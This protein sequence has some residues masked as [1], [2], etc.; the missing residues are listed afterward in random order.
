MPEGRGCWGAPFSQRGALGSFPPV[1]YTPLTDLGL[2]RKAMMIK[3]TTRRTSGVVGDGTTCI[4]EAVL[5][6]PRILLPSLSVLLRNGI[7]GSSQSTK[8]LESFLF[9]EAAPAFPSSALLSARASAGSRSQCRR[10]RARWCVAVGGV[11]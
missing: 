10:L 6:H 3:L 2:I 1:S 11:W 9:W 5:A 8:T 7:V 4:K